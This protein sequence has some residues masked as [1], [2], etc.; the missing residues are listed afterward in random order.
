M[1]ELPFAELTEPIVQ[2]YYEVFNLPN[3]GGYPEKA[4]CN[5]LESKLKARGLKV[6][7][8]LR[9]T[10]RMGNETIGEGWIDLVVG[11]KVIVVVKNVLRM[12]SN[13][14][15]QAA[16]YKAQGGYPAGLLLNFGGPKPYHRRIPVTSGRGGK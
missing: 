6:S 9:L 11:G 4:L 12:T 13:I 3:V 1:S 2:A 16:L 14:T 10:L 5:M 15:E 8:N 7:A